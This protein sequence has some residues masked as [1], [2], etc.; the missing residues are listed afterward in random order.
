[1]Q[2]V[3]YRMYN[4]QEA[5]GPPNNR[6]LGLLAKLLQVYSYGIRWSFFS[7]RCHKVI[8]RDSKHFEHHNGPLVE[9]KMKQVACSKAGSTAISRVPKHP[10]KFLF[11]EFVGGIWIVK[12]REH[13]PPALSHYHSY[14]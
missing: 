12:A 7:L 4:T 5:T 10:S 2:G 6:L 11:E 8:A 13:L 3:L 9:Q 14:N 1:M